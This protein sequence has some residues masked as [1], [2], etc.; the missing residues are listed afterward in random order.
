MQ[1]KFLCPILAE[2]IRV[3]LWW[4]L[5][6]LSLVKARSLELF[7]VPCEKLVLELGDRKYLFAAG[8]RLNSIKINTDICTVVANRIYSAWAKNDYSVNF[9]HGQLKVNQKLRKSYRLCSQVSLLF[10]KNYLAPHTSRWKRER[11]CLRK[12]LICRLTELCPHHYL[13]GGTASRIDAYRYTYQS[14]VLSSY[15]VLGGKEQYD[16]LARRCFLKRTEA[17]F[18]S[19]AT[20]LYRLWLLIG[21]IL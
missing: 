15:Y 2:G 8:A 20:L 10:F 5:R 9:R 11:R 12:I 19:L 17:N 6:L 13:G 3:L 14:L 7:T 16:Y 18:Q 1:K 21:I 4:L